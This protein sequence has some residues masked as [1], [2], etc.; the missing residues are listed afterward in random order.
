M[1]KTALPFIIEYLKK[2]ALRIFFLLFFILVSQFCEQMATLY[3]AKVFDMAGRSALGNPEWKPMAYALLISLALGAITVISGFGGMFLTSKLLP[4]IRSMVVKDAFEYVNKHSISYFYNE[5]SG[6]I[7]NKVGL[8]HSG[9]TD[10]LRDLTNVAFHFLFIFVNIVI[11]STVNGWLGLGTFIWFILTALVGIKLGKTRAAYSKESGKMQSMASAMVVDSIAN[12]SEIKSFANYKFERL[13]LLKYLR[14]YRSAETKERRFSAIAHLFLESISTLS[15]IGFSFFALALLYFNKISTAEFIFICTVFLRLSGMVFGISW[16]TNNIS[17]NVGKINS[18]LS[19]LAIEP[20]IVDSPKAIDQTFKTAQI[21]FE[22]VKFSYADKGD[23]FENLSLTIKAGEKI[24]LVGASGAGK[25][26]FIKLLSRYFDVTEGGIKINDIDIR[27][28]KQDSL[29]RNISVMPQDVCLF[30]RTLAENIRYGKTNASDAEVENAAK[31]AFAD[32]FINQF[33]K[34]YETKVG[35][36]GVV[37]SGGEKQRVAIARA[38]LKNAPILIFD[39]ATSA[40]DS[41]SEAYIQKSLNN[42]MKGKTVIAIAHRLSTLREMDRIL[43]FEK[44]RIVE[45]GTHRS[46]LRQKGVYAKLY[47]MQAEGFVK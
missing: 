47:K 21:T 27:D 25:S 32:I 2:F 23:L 40:L 17:S 30:N 16:I 19:T 4:I 24:G 7:S 42:L 39:E 36:R 14:K 45:E 18:A 22:N 35:E 37:L 46:L 38:I 6:N 1:K 43:V 20:E 33:P 13:N 10:I 5:M 31:Q 29:H 11:L 15:S 41:A 3:L 9:V 28:L 34:G 8:L 12:Y 26:T 44:G